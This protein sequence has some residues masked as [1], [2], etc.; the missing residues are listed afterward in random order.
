MVELAFR[1][2][3]N[4]ISQCTLTLYGKSD[5]GGVNFWYADNGT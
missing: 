3:D 1:H 2:A 4:G 5:D